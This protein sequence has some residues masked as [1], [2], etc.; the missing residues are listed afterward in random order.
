MRRMMGFALVLPLLVALQACAFHFNSQ[1][2]AKTTL[3]QTVGHVPGSSL[4]VKTRNGWV[5]VT[6]EPQRSDVSIETR[7]QCVGATQQEADDRLAQATMSVTRG[8]DGVLVI[9]PIF[10][11]GARGG[12]GASITIVLP[13][14]DGVELD[15]SNGPVTAHDLTGK[16]VIDTSNGSVVVVNHRGS[17]EIDTSN[18]PITIT[19]HTGSLLIDTSNGVVH[20]VNLAGPATIDTSNG[21]IDLS[22]GADHSGPLN[23][24]TSNGS[25]RVRVGEGFVGP[26]TLDTSNASI[27]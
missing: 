24:D 27:V 4:V 12:D 17:A 10:P 9:K 14:A 5:D 15:T 23:L 22:L 13:D 7:L 20:V 18:G 8:P 19:D 6:A 26:V 3:S 11:G 21:P 1:A 16:L 2:K 25:I